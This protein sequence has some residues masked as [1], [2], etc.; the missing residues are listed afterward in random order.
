MTSATP[1]P[2]EPGNQAATKAS[3][4]FS[5]GLTHIARPLMKIETT[6]MPCALRRFKIAKSVL[7]P[8]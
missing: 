5:S 4:A 3:D 7:L 6:G 1:L 2:S 8:G